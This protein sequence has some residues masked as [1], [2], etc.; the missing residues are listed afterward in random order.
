MIFIHRDIQLPCS[1]AM[2]YNY[3]PQHKWTFSYHKIGQLIA[4]SKKRILNIKPTYDLKSLITKQL[5]AKVR[6][7]ES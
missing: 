6:K 7:L 4:P 2:N 1:L 5:T 3:K